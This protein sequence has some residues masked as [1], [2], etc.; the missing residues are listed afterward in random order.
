MRGRGRGT[1]QM[2]L[3]EPVGVV[4]AFTPWNFPALT[5]ARK[6]AAALAAGCSVIIK[7]SE[8]TP[9]ACVELVRCFVDAGTPAGVVNL[10]FGVPAKISEYLIA[11][12]VVRKI[13]FT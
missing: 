11:S 5:P 6:I 9:G 13:S 3:Q 12:D 2:V 1:R 10:V 4:A 7:A 8:E